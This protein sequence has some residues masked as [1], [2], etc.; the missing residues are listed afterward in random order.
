MTRKLEFLEPM[1]AAI[2]SNNRT[3]RPPGY[4]GGE[5]GQTGRN[6]VLHPDGSLTE[7]GPVAEF[8]IQR[9]DILIIETPGGGGWGVAD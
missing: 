6:A 4:A 1:Q 7:H 5:P 8:D 2:L 3:T 9:G